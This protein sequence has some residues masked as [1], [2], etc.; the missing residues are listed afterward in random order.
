MS[1]DKNVISVP[2]VMR[3]VPEGCPDNLS[4]PTAGC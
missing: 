2:Q 1:L 3:G 4:Q